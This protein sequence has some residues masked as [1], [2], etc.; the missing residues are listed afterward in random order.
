[1]ERHTGQPRDGELGLRERKKRRTRQRIADEATLLILDRG[2]ENVTVAEVAAAAE[3][4]TMTVFNHFPRKEDLFLDRVPEG[5]E[6]VTRAVEDRRPDETPLAALRRNVLAFLDERHPFGAVGESFPR[7]WQV[8]LDSPALRSR[9]REALGELED[10]LAAAFARAAGEDPAAPGTDARLTAA[11]TVAA[12][13]TAYVTT[14]RRQLAGTGA[15]EAAVGHRALVHQ[16][17]DALERAVNRPRPAEAASA[18][19]A[20]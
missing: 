12:Y 9:A 13:R 8:V 4:S 15:D 5:I 2:F 18:P 19:P 3:V 16:A 11:L 14:A 20:P 6:A 10:A 7:F 17:F 1:M